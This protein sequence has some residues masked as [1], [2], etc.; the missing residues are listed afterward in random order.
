[1]QIHTI[2]GSSIQDALAEARARLGDGVVLLESVAATADQ[3]A[4]ITVMMD[5]S[6]PAAVPARAVPALPAMAPAASAAAPPMEV[7]P[8]APLGFGYGASR[9][10]APAPRRPLFTAPTTAPAYAPAP[11]PAPAPPPVAAPAPEVLDRLDRLDAQLGG[12]L[13][14]VDRLDRLERQLGHT[15]L[16]GSQP[17]TA[18][19]LYGR[20]LRSGL[21]PKTAHALLGPAAERGLTPDAVSDDAQMALLWSVAQ[22]LR[23]RLHPTAPRRYAADTLVAV[24]PSGAGKTTFLTRVATDDRFYGRRDVGVLVVAPEGG[25]G[26]TDPGAPYRLHGLATRTV[27][28][29]AEVREALDRFHGTSALLVDTPALPADETA[30]RQSLARLAEILSPLTSCDVVLTL[31]AARARPPFDLAR[32]DTLP[33]PITLGAVTRL[34]EAQD[35]GRVAEWLLAFD[36]PVGFAGMGAGL[37]DAL[38]PYSPAWFVESFAHR[39]G[40]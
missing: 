36:R 1:M 6:R 17:W 30:A 14:L 15:L 12:V 27:Q 23:D 25:A 21:T 20:L 13:G 10:A 37:D 35:W 33:I 16:S 19:P 31:D 18:N 22:T 38:L 29:A 5:A 3:P 4:R 34:D 28:S 2:T 24:G 40:A 26:G 8:P 32:L 7:E 11:M 39:L 9:P